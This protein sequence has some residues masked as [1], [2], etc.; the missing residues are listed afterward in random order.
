[1]TNWKGAYG[2]RQ[3]LLERNEKW[4]RKYKQTPRLFARR[5]LI[6]LEIR[7]CNPNWGL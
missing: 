3:L 7:Y 5:N 2:K 4:C 1:M 6:K